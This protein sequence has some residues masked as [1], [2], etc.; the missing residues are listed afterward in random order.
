MEAR[1][2]VVVAVALIV[3]ALG[4]VLALRRR[5]RA[6]G[7]PAAVAPTPSATDR[8]RRGLVA[9]RERLLGQLD[10]VLARAPTDAERV[11]PEL[12]EALVAAD[13]GVRTAAELVARVRSRVG[14][15]ENTG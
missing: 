3:L 15:G 12:E 9:T 14:R 8:L 10:A 1:W 11:Y 13:V 2:V 6:R 5:P 7:A 4:L